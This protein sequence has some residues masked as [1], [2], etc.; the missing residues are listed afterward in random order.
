MLVTSGGGTNFMVDTGKVD[1]RGQLSVH[2]ENR[3]LQFVSS[4]DQLGPYL[5]G[6]R[7]SALLV[8]ITNLPLNNLKSGIFVPAQATSDAR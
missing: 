3:Q 1:A 2:S 5:S 7:R 8:R 4:L 6:S